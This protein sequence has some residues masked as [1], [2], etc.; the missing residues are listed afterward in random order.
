MVNAPLFAKTTT[1]AASSAVL[2]KPPARDAGWLRQA[3]APQATTAT[4]RVRRASACSQGLKPLAVTQQQFTALHAA[5]AAT[6]AGLAADQQTTLA[7]DRIGSLAT[8]EPRMDNWATCHGLGAGASPTKVLDGTYGVTVTQAEVV[9]SGDR[10]DCGN[11]YRL[12][13]HDGRYP[14]YHP[15]TLNNPDEPSMSFFRAWRPDDRAEVGTISIAGNRAMLVPEV[16]QQ[17]GSAPT[18]YRCDPFP[19]LLTLASAVRDRH[20]HYS[21]LEAAELSPPAAS[22]RLTPQSRCN[23]HIAVD[24]HH[25]AHSHRL[26]IASRVRD[27]NKGGEHETSIPRHCGADGTPARRSAGRAELR[28]RLSCAGGDRGCAGIC[29]A[30]ASAGRPV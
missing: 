19:S 13:G 15:V 26:D 9:A 16:N 17:N 28:G 4:D 30:P 20:G 8:Q 7:I 21:P 22:G 11:S 27:A 1:L 6:Y 12:A 10:A 23:A 29:V 5:E 14:L 3:A 24:G 18:A 2:A 25:Q